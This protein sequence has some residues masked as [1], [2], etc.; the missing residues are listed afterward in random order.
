[1]RKEA[2][3]LTQ[4]EKVFRFIKE[5]MKIP[6]T[7]EE[8]AVM[9]SVPKQDMTKFVEILEHLE[10]NGKIV[11]TKKK[12]YAA[13]QTLGMASG[14]FIGNERGFGFVEQEN[15]EGQDIF[16][17]ADHTGGALHGDTVL[18][19]ASHSMHFDKIVDKLNTH[20]E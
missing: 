20:F 18:V 17:K 5:D 16:I 1:M 8:I 6:M 12:R 9:L 15:A 2:Y 10:A 7:A 4:E 11:R 14:K 13:C 19:K 3:H